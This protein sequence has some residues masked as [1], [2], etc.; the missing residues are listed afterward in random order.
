MHPDQLSHESALEEA[1]INCTHDIP[2][3]CL[4]CTER[5]VRL[6]ILGKWQ[7]VFH[8]LLTKEIEGTIILDTDTILA[9]DLTVG[10]LLNSPPK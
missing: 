6:A 10:D 3:L 8:V 4:E 7:R 1:A 2:T 9:T 5:L